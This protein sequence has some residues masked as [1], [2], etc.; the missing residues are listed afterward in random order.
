[1][2]KQ[3]KKRKRGGPCPPAHRRKSTNCAVIA[4]KTDKINS[5]S[6]CHNKTVSGLARET[7]KKSQ[8]WY[9]IITGA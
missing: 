7:G 9:G 4:Y 6:T 3:R 1:M 2:T 8:R 5:S